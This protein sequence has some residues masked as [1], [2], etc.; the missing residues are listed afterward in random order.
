MIRAV[1]FLFNNSVSLF[2]F[3]C[4]ASYLLLSV[5]SGCGKQEVTL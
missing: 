1:S 4:A 3:G 2:I 5:F